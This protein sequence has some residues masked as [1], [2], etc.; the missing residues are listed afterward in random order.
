MSIELQK[1]FWLDKLKA[2][3]IRTKHN[4]SGRLLES[5]DFE[6]TRSG[7]DYE[8]KLIAE[9][10]IAIINKRFM[11]LFTPG[12]GAGKSQ[13]I[14][15]PLEWAKHVK[16]GLSRTQQRQFAFKTAR[17]AISRR[18]KGHPT[19]NPLYGVQRLNFLARVFD[20]KVNQREFA[21][22]IA[23]NID[24]RPINVNVNIEL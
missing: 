9:P 18:T 1:Q 23:I 11:P 19:R 14:E 5:L 22:L 8:L 3:L 20:S 2:E 7:E 17:K 10:Y 6:I 21:K 12:S 24:E 16:P 4:A 13:Y 15:G